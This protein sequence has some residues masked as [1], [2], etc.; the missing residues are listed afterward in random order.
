MRG[1]RLHAHPRL[2]D[3]A[4]RPLR[5]GEH[6]VGA[7]ARARAGQPPRLP[8]AGRRD[9]A[10]RLDE[11]LDV[12][13][14]ASRSGRPRAWRSSR[15]ASRTRT[16]A[17]SGA[18]SGRARRAGASSA[19][20]SAPAWMRAER[21]TAST[22]STRSSAPQVD[23]DDAVVA[24]PRTRGVTPPTT[25]V[26]P[27]KGIAATRSAA[28]HSSSALDLALIAR[29]RDE[30][31]RMLEAPAKAAHHVR[32]GL[33]RARATRAR[34]RRSRR[35]PRAPAGGCDARRRQLDR[36]ERHRLLDLAERRSRGAP[37]SA[38]RRARAACAACG[39]WSSKP[40][41]QC[42]RRRPLTRRRV[43]GR[44]QRRAGAWRS[45]TLPALPL[46][47]S[48]DV[49]PARASH[50]PPEILAR[51]PWPLE[52]VTRALA[53]G[54]VRA[55]ARA[56]ARPPTRRSRSCSERGSPSHDGV[57]ARL[58]DYRQD[59]RGDRDRAAA[60]ALGAAPGRRRRLA[61]RGRAVRHALGRRPLA[62]RDGAR[63]GSPRGP[64]AG[65]SAPAARS[66]S[67]RTRPTRSCA[68]CGRSGRSSPERV[69]GEALL[70]L[71]HQLVMFVGQAW[72]AEGAEDDGHARPRARRVRLVAARDRRLAAGGRR[73]AA[74]DGSLALGVSSAAR[75]SRGAG[76]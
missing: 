76:R 60:A 29:A 19:G 55:S 63:R 64:A 41:P 7:H 45:A 57:A 34:A 28:H 14:H 12:R 49:R 52:Q 75:A 30:V 10:H 23:R 37:P 47:L 13:P 17:G 38:A 31:G 4:E 40:Q 69:R 15:R 3:H 51:G 16:T 72:L 25:D 42:L 27:P 54:A 61:E 33:A 2:G 18:A 59:E 56:H 46:A 48:A 20:P 8:R 71:P 39:C 62:G 35:S 9:R 65:R 74:A 11:V 44:A 68:S 43:Y 50:E 24:E 53:R 66:T 5:A 26:P 32:V 58:V 36:L 21:E 6:P 73:D 22:S 67:A 70:R 1:P